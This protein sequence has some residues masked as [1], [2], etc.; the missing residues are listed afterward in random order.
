MN[1]KSN[2]AILIAIL[3]FGVIL[4]TFFSLYNSA[5]EP[6]SFDES[7]A[8]GAKSY[9]RTMEGDSM[10]PTIDD[11]Q[12]IVFREKE[13]YQIRDIVLF[14]SPNRMDNLKRIIA[15]EGDIVSCDEENFLEVNGSRYTFDGKNFAYCM[16]M[17]SEEQILEKKEFFVLGDN[18]DL[19]FDSRSFGPIEISRIKG[20][21]VDF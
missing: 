16:N 12:L 13:S 8:D 17:T 18:F 20:A 3:I 9:L 11:G 5:E 14:S 15:K 10:L 1:R 19:S 6:S 21:L 7:E 4:F 2:T